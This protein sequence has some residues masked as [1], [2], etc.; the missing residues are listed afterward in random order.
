MRVVL[1]DAGETATGSMFCMKHID[2]EEK[3]RI[4]SSILTLVTVS[5]SF[6]QLNQLP[7]HVLRLLDPEANLGVNFSPLRRCSS[8]G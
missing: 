1:P 3:N 2:H 6:P 5:C 7:F 4:L 8:G